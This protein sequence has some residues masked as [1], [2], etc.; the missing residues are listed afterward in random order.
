M[1][2]KFIRKVKRIRVLY[3]ATIHGPAQVPAAGPP[4]LNLY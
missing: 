3:V 2:L 4:P 1:I